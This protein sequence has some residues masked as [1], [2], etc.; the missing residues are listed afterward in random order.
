[1]LLLENRKG[2]CVLSFAAAPSKDDQHQVRRVSQLDITNLLAPHRAQIDSQPLA[3]RGEHSST[4]LFAV[5]RPK[6]C[7]RQNLSP[8]L[9]QPRQ[10]FSG[11]FGT[12]D[13]LLAARNNSEKDHHQINVVGLVSRI[14]TKSGQQLA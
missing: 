1:M 4:F 6:F 9:E 8:Q 12:S 3:T 11:P 2:H 7:H 5:E 13:L 14:L 10:D